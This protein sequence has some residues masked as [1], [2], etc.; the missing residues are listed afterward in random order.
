MRKSTIINVVVVLFA[1]VAFNSVAARDWS[2]CVLNYD[3]TSD[4]RW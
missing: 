1:A 3:D 4:K 2:L